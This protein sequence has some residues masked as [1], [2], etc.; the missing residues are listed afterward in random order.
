M[1]LRYLEDHQ[2]WEKTNWFLVFRQGRF[3]VTTA[4]VGGC[5]LRKLLVLRTLNEDEQGPE[6]VS[7]KR[8]V[9]SYAAFT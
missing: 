4:I 6:P 3:I 9:S 1:A 2:T 5:V 7:A 8:G